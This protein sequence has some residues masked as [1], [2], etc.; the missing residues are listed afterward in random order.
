MS[1]DLDR[2]VGADFEP[3]LDAI[4]DAVDR[5]DYGDGAYRDLAQRAVYTILRGPDRGSFLGRKNKVDPM[6]AQ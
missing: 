1:T 4:R 3:K 5:G 2:I 6:T